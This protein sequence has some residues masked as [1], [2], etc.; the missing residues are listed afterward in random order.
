MTFYIDVPDM[1]DSMS[2]I[3]LAGREY[4]IR[5]TF[6]AL[7]EYWSFSLYDTNQNLLLGMIRIVPLSPLTEY[8]T[9]EELPAGKFG[10]ESQGEINRQAFVDKTA[11]FFFIPNTDLEGWDPYG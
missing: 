10:C 8:Y 5:F 1:N 6:N 9:H 7:H 4:F 11:K 2:R 3:T